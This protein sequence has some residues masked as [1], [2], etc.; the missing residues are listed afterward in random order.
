MLAS[1]SGFVL[2]SSPALTRASYNIDDRLPITVEPKA[3]AKPA[4]PSVVRHPRRS[5]PAPDARRRKSRTAPTS[6]SAPAP[7]SGKRH[8]KANAEQHAAKP[9]G[10]LQIVISIDQQ[11]L[12]LYAGG[13]AVAHSRVS[14]GVPGHPT[15]TGAFSIIQKNRFHHSN[16]YSG[17]PMPFMQ[18]ITW[19]GVALHEGV[20]PGRPASHGCIRLPAA[21]AK[22]LWGWTKLGA[23]VVVT[24][25][26]TEPHEMS[27]P[28][29]AAL[30]SGHAPI[31]AKT[32]AAASPRADATV[33]G[34]Q[35]SPHLTRTAASMV[36]ANDATSEDA[37]AD[38]K[39]VESAAQ[40]EAS[41][42]VAATPAIDVAL[43]DYPPPVSL[44][45]APPPAPAPLRRFIGIAD[46]DA[47][48]RQA[49][50][51]VAAA[52]VASGDTD[53]TVSATL[54]LGVP[55][56]PPAVTLDVASAPT[57]NLDLPDY[58]PALTLDVGP[59]HVAA[60]TEARAPT[61]PATIEIGVPNYP[62][63]AL[64]IPL[65]ELAAALIFERPIQKGPVSVFISRKDRK[66]YVRQDFHPVFSAPVT[67]ERPD[68]P[69]GTH[70]FTALAVNDDGQTMR[71][72]ALTLPNAIA[73]AE[74]HRTS[75][76]DKHAKTPKETAA[77]H[78]LPSA[79]DAL[80]RVTIP[81]AVAQRVFAFMAPGSSLVISDQGLGPETGR[82]TDFIVLTR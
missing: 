58:P 14:T 62:P 43:P 32:P 46:A 52:A 70:I 42:S 41:A 68:A 63:P 10:P 30:T 66:L 1:V 4:A 48:A 72:N 2:L 64:D 29:L 78:H 44:D 19:S 8:E 17:A 5:G 79:A 6:T 3:D 39:R 23:R 60:V 28:R 55:D 20:V 61:P 81:P 36:I 67:I 13:T 16:I 50:R 45:L 7:A 65:N 80:E 74:L 9:N 11:S 82:G 47:T 31:A 27:H 56:Y 34:V 77:P 38:A 71:W 75:A 26:P 76:R 33:P 35:P 15:P 24:R 22:Q 53:I 21:F 25:G 18:R 73:K 54:D 59:T 37:P 49:A 51:D 57:V 12:T 40:T 69:L